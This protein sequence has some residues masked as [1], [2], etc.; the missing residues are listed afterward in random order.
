MKIEYNS[1]NIHI[2][3]SVI[4]NYMDTLKMSKNE[5]ILTWLEEEGYEENAELDSLEQKAKENKITAT[6]HGAEKEGKKTNSTPK[7]R[8]RKEDTIKR[9]IIAF[10]FGSLQNDFEGTENVTVINPEK[11]ISFT[12]NGDNYE[13]DLRRKRKKKGE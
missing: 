12:M 5:A 10:L 3:D 8:K 4:Q 6:I 2:P 1:K 7:E 9:N 11:L 13:L